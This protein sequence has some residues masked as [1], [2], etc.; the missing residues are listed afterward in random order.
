MR[1]KCIC[2]TEMYFVHLGAFGFVRLHQINQKFLNIVQEPF[3]YLRVKFKK[4][5]KIFYFKN[6][7]IYTE[8]LYEIQLSDY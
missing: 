8:V 4:F 1:R 7:I 6:G 5:L 3:F 2:V